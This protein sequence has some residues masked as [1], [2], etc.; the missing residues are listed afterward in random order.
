MSGCDISCISYLM[1]AFL[2]CVTY[3]SLCV[4]IHLR[5]TGNLTALL[6]MQKGH[7]CRTQ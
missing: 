7:Q 6:E 5:L 1:S 4:L 2:N 3:I